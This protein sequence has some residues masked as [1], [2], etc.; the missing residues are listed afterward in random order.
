MTVQC[1]RHSEGTEKVISCKEDTN[2]DQQ[3]ITET[4]AGPEFPVPSVP[5]RAHLC[6]L[7]KGQPALSNTC[8]SK[9]HDQGLTGKTN[10]LH[11][12]RRGLWKCMKLIMGYFEG[13][14][15]M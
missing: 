7:Q 2:C 13:I 4:I 1:R 3:Q 6:S 14:V 9:H 8:E 15:G 12:I 5:F 10:I 11:N